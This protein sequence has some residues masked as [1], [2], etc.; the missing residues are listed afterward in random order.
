MII[1]IDARRNHTGEWGAKEPCILKL[2][3]QS[4]TDIR[5]E[6]NDGIIIVD[7][8]ELLRAV[9]AVMVK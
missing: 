2:E 3:K 6:T 7:A 4:D 9:K 5:L 8:D 1:T